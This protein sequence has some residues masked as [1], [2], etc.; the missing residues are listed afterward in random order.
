L[1]LI[2]TIV[3]KFAFDTSMV[4]NPL[5][6]L[7]VMLT[8]IGIQLL[9]TGLLGEVLARTYF[10]SQDKRPYLVREFRNLSEQRMDGRKAA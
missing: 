10:E 7:S 5:L 6:L 2:A 4:R 1:S 3:V 9:S 8:L